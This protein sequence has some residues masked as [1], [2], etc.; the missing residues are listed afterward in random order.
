MPLSLLCQ[1]KR[2][3]PTSGQLSGEWDSGRLSQLLVN[4]VA[5]ALNHGDADGEVR[6]D[7]KSNK[8][9]VVLAVQNFGPVVS[10]SARRGMFQPLNRNSKVHNADSTGSSGLGLGLYIAHQ[11]AIAHHDTLDVVSTEAAGTTFT[12]CLPLRSNMY[13]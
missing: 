4:L 3:L 13:V 11:I 6:V 5:N 8:N 10:E 9:G 2:N 12:A 1:V 7:L